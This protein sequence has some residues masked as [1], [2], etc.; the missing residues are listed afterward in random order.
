VST[1]WSSY[2]HDVRNLRWTV[3][4]Q[5]VLERVANAL[6]WGPERTLLEIGAGRGI[7]SKQLFEMM[8]SEEPD[9]YEVCPETILYMKRVGLNAIGDE[10]ELK[11]SYD[12]AWSYG[13]PEHFEEPMRQEIID[14]HFERSRDWVLLVIPRNTW[15]RRAVARQDRIP[16]RDFSD[17]E[18]RKRLAAGAARHW[19][20]AEV[21]IHVESFC[22]LFGVRHIP[23]GW[24]N[25]V[26]RLIGWALPGGLLLGWARKRGTAGEAG[27]VTAAT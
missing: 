9:L 12:I 11:G 20:R 14:Q 25:V 10:N 21:D 8:R 26:D 22:P 6:G 17:E 16:A 24:Y 27:S 4:D 2:W 1:E 13:V 5:E 15:F 7:H 18:L 19:G 23:L 3:I